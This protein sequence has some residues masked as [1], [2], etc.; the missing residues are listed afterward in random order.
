MA[1]SAS[2]ARPGFE[3]SSWAWNV[4]C[5]WGLVLL[6]YV[7]LCCCVIDCNCPTYF[8]GMTFTSH[9]LTY[10]VQKC[11][12]NE[13]IPETFKQNIYETHCLEWSKGKFPNSTT[14]IIITMT[15]NT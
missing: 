14:L 3:S 9:T 15:K 6:C 12:Y 11:N 7:M 8:R 13:L 4:N 2:T 10:N 1:V 5:I